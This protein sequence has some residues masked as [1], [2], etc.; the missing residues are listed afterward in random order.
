MKKILNILGKVILMF[1]IFL[2]IVF[3]VYFIIGIFYAYNNGTYESLSFGRGLFKSYETIYGKEAIQLYLSKSFFY[4]CISSMLGILPSM[5]VP[6]FVA[7]ILKFK[8]IFSKTVFKYVTIAL[9][10]LIILHIL[11]FY[12]FFDIGLVILPYIE[13][14]LISYL[15]AGTIYK[16]III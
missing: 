6:I 8:R 13:S 5:L 10:G 16:K 4:F 1:C 2:I 3:V 14:I 15:I 11:T 9:L 7:I 12:V